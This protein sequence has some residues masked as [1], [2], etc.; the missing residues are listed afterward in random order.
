MDYE[1]PEPSKD[2]VSALV[3]YYKV[4]RGFE[5]DDRAWDKIHFPRCMRAAKE[6]L[7]ICGEF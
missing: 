1:I 4:M 6:L 2:P 3:I 5:F 7:S